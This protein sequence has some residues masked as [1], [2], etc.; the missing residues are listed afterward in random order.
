MATDLPLVPAEALGHTHIM[1]GLGTAFSLPRPEGERV[2]RGG[3]DG[4]VTHRRNPLAC[5]ED[6]ISASCEVRRVRRP[7]APPRVGGTEWPPGPC[8]R[9][10]ASA[11]PPSAFFLHTLE[12]GRPAR[13]T[14][15]RPIHRPT[16]SL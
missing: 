1:I 16:P 12:R 3:H 8:H 7:S 6:R 5:S 14:R 13:K 2:G 15:Q 9:R 4:S 11:V 10:D